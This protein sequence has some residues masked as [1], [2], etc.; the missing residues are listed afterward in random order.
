M[1][2]DSSMGAY[3]KDGRVL[4]VR[5]DGLAE[6]DVQRAWDTAK[7]DGQVDAVFFAIGGE[8]SIS[9]LKG[10]VITPADL[11]A[12]SMAVLLAVIQSS[13][14][15]STR[16]KLVTITSNGLDARSHSLLPFPLKVFYG[17]LLPIPNKDKVAQEN[18]VKRA[19]GWEDGE[20]WLG[21]NNLVIVQPS[22]L[23]SGECVADKKEN[24]Y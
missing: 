4:L 19:A 18:H 12:R 22:I 10:A 20:G 16:P 1:E 23:T 14:T 24:A 8:A 3:I 9:L 21:S 5:G 15:L 7:G 17:W 11:T 6:A 2:S 13:T